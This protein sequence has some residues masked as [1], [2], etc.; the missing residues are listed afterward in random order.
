MRKLSTCGNY[1][2]VFANITFDWFES[3]YT[4]MTC[5]FGVVDS[6]YCSCYLGGEFWDVDL[7][8]LFHWGRRVRE[9]ARGGDIILQLG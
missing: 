3:V 6:K 8:S 9:S 2:V 1:H 5:T 4:K 7:T